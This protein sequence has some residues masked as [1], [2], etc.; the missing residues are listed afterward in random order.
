MSQIDV[1]VQPSAPEW[2]QIL[3]ALGPCFLLLAAG[4]VGFIW[5]LA[6]REETKAVRRNDQWSRVAWA[7][8]AS[9]DANPQKRRAGHA[10][11][12]VLNR[13]AVPG[14]REA[15]II[16]QARREVPDAKAEHQP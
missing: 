2:W 13:E 4:I 7:I 11:L 3:A 16:A 15:K 6:L 1:Y 12:D 9:V 5:R 14:S 10:A 8:E